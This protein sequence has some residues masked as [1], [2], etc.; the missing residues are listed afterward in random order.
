MTTVSLRLFETAG[1]QIGFLK[2]RVNIMSVGP[3]GN[4]EM[5]MPVLSPSLSYKAVR[6]SDLLVDRY[7]RVALSSI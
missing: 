3:M 6:N 4:Y 7:L 5:L 1:E 2:S